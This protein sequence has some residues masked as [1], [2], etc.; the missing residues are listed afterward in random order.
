MSLSLLLN[1][2]KLKGRILFKAKSQTWNTS[3][4]HELQEQVQASK[5]REVSCKDKGMLHMQGKGH[6]IAACPIQQDEVGSD[7]TGQTG[8][9]PE[10]PTSHLQV[11]SSVKF[12]G[13]AQNE[14]SAE[15]QG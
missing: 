7:Q 11:Q 5:K 8:W 12:M 14:A 1:K 2:V 10:C 4:L 3:L 15:Y 13:E 6:L 9:C